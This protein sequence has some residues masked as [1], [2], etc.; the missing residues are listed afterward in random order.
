MDRLIAGS[1][2]FVH[3]P[4]PHL[5]VLSSLIMLLP[6]DSRKAILKFVRAQ[7]GTRK[8]I[9]KLV[10]LCTDT[11]RY[12][13]LSFHR[14]PYH[15]RQQLR[16]LFSA[17]FA[18][19]IGD[20][21]R[22]GFVSMICRNLP[23]DRDEGLQAFR[24]SFEKEIQSTQGL[25]KGRFA[26]YGAV[27]YNGALELWPST[28]V[29][30]REML[31]NSTRRAMEKFRADLPRYPLYP[32]F[33]R[34][35]TLSRD[36]AD[37]YWDALNPEHRHDCRE[38]MVTGR[39]LVQLYHETGEKI[40]G[41]PEVRQAWKYND[42]K[43]RTYYSSG[44]STFWASTYLQDF[45]NRLVDMF[46]STH[47]RARFHLD[48]FTDIPDE[49]LI[50][51]YDYTSFTSSMEEQTYFLQALAEFFRGTDVQ[52]VDVREGLV[53]KDMGE[54]LDDYIAS[55]QM[56]EFEIRRVL[57]I[58]AVFRQMIAGFLG[59]YGNIASCTFLH[60]L[61]LSQVTINRARSRCV[62]DDALGQILKQEDWTLS[63]VF[64]AL[65][66]NGELSAD[67]SSILDCRES[68]E[69]QV[70]YVKRPLRR[71]FGR[72]E[73]GHLVD[74]PM[75]HLLFKSSVDSIH[76]NEPGSLFERQAM[77]ITQTRR[78]LDRIASFRGSIEDQTHE[79]MRWYLGYGYRCLG[80]PE[81]GEIPRPG[82]IY[83]LM[84]IPPILEE[85]STD[86]KEWLLQKEYGTLVNVP[87]WDPEEGYITCDVG[88]STIGQGS[89]GL[90][91]LVDLGYITRR[92]NS[93]ETFLVGPVYDSYFEFLRGERRLQYLFEV[94]S[95]IPVHLEFLLE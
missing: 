23:V 87:I 76:T 74:I 67:K 94:I 90:S 81:V 62:G 8:R 83:P 6:L 65:R 45:F 30:A 88:S 48:S 4:D 70:D 66:I 36:T 10:Q 73:P 18:H 38:S 92:M 41:M 43:P 64:D 2:P 15:N 37:H 86:W 29:G 39:D 3:G 89:K 68:P 9:A 55:C 79:F 75:F 7:C 33:S 17:L 72:L 50:V 47:R 52:V 1:L 28:L 49:D 82:S 40:S 71:L 57:S 59:V 84:P 63:S 85:L 27:L 51:I 91:L 61:G 35:R 11:F 22:A 20:P 95:P 54:M 19:A 12:S 26:N 93:C 58:E 42:L 56:V 31:N 16:D 14:I 21:V 78:F 34:S 77:F 69:D 60:G 44:G 32:R 5:D 25:R 24:S 46:P 53:T 80:L 13:Q